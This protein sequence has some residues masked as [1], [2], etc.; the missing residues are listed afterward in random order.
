MTPEEKLDIVNKYALLKVSL[1]TL[2]RAAKNL[3]EAQKDYMNHRGDDEKGKIVGRKAEELDKA[4][5]TVD[6]LNI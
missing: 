6:L 1:T 5:E 2:L 3:R 4:I